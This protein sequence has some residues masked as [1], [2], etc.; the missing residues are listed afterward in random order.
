MYEAH[1]APIPAGPSPVSGVGGLGVAVHDGAVWAG[2]AD[3]QDVVWEDDVADPLDALLAGPPV[4]AEQLVDQVPGSEL[5]YLLEEA[6][7]G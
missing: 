5:A 4:A 2:E 3:W 1:S 7:L 6:L